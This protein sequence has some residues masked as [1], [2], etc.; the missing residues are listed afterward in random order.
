MNLQKILRPVMFGLLFL[1]PIFPLIV[2]N[3][4]FFPFITGKAFYFRI[5]VELAFAGWVILAFLDAKYRPKFSPLTVAISIFALVTLLADL[6]GVNPLRSI[7]SNF[8]RMEGWLAIMHLWAY[9]MVAVHFFGTD[10][11]G[12]HWWHWWFNAS[13]IVATI[14]GIYGFVQLFGWAAIHQGSTRIDASLGNAAYMAVY[15]LI[16]AFLAAYMCV[17]E[18][19]RRHTAQARVWVYGILSIIFAFLVFQTA[20][21]GTILALIGGVILSLGLYAIF[22]KKE[23]TKW[24]GISAGII[25]VIILIGV[26][27]WVNRDATFV[28]NS[29]VLSRLATIS[30]NETKTQARGY[31]WPM[32]IQGFKDRPI[33]GWGQENFNYIFNANY[34]PAMWSQEQWFDRAHNVYLDWLTASGAVG[35]LVYLSLYV[36][37]FIAIWKSSVGIKEKSILTGLVAS[38]AVHNIFVFDNLAS[39]VMFFSVLGF[40]NYFSAP[41]PIR[42]LGAKPLRQDAVE[43]IVAPIVVVL[44]VVTLYFIN[45]RPIQA[46]TRLIVAL[47]YCSGGQP[48]AAL[49]EKVFALDQYMAN[50][51]AREQTISCTNNVLNGQ[52]PNPTKTAFA[53]LASGEVEKQLRATPNDARIYA[54][55]G[56]LYNSIGQ[57]ELSIPLV[58]KAIELSPGKQSIILQLVNAYVNTGKVD[59]AL[60]LL[61]EMYEVTPAHTEVKNVYAKVL[62]YAGRE[63]EARELFGADPS[64]FESESTAQMYVASK[65]Y[66]KAIELYK[67]LVA[68]D[69][70]NINLRIQLA[71]T[72]YGA[73]LKT[74]SL[75]TLRQMQTDFPEY[76]ANIEK[77]ITELQKEL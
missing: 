31:I 55:A 56:S 4:Y 76:K 19:A 32:A 12:L 53:K 70:Q 14:V 48:D 3:S 29:E 58:Q 16:H 57:Y 27:F 63:A 15:M 40:L 26:L 41:K 59:E 36:L 52:Y 73:G 8:E 25:A 65:Q 47:S 74:M 42:W 46:N 69:S 30:I 34:N 49:F 10:K 24:R 71:Q 2:A 23:S 66:T 75:Q 33:L 54:I 44:M 67:K 18:R 39:Y 68:A 6:I 51:E 62:I 35:L 43:Y 9:F 77:N 13:L 45:V 21:R 17:A 20:T 60:Q 72:Y 11:E 64:I 7:W 1:I 37:A 50:Q 28:K 61:K 5:L 22:G 38:Y